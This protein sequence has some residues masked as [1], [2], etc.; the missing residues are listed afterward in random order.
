MAVP[1]HHSPTWAPADE[2]F[3]VEPSDETT[4]DPPT[5]GLYIGQAGDVI[6]DMAKSGTNILYKSVPAGSVL[7]IS[8]VRV[9]AATVAQHIVALY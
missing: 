3:A 5:R 4:F 9:K 6:V 7:P 1:T 8:V 2:A